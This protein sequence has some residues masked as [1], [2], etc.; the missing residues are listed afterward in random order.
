M[1]SANGQ[2]SETDFPL[3]VVLNGDSASASE[4]VAGALQDHG[5]AVIVGQPSFGKGSVQTIFELPGEQALKLTIARYYTPLG[6]SIQN[7]GIIP[8]VWIQ[9]VMKR[10]S[11]GNLLGSFR[12]RNERFLKNSLMAKQISS[13]A[14]NNIFKTKLKSYYLSDE[15]FDEYAD[16]Q[17][18]DYEMDIALDILEE[19]AKS[20][21]A[22]GDHSGSRAAHWLA[23]AMPRVKARTKHYFARVRSW[24]KNKHKVTW[25]ESSKSDLS[26]SSMSFDSVVS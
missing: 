16:N 17:K 25:A 10:P 21:V 14:I 4:V 1:E 8:D 24:L 22:V 6:R 12:Y 5:R 7:V 3:V 26:K 18:N 13:K 19:N 23:L 20:R 11:N 15:E 9:P 2:I